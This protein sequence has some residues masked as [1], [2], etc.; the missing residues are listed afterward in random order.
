M[1]SQTLAGIA[2]LFLSSFAS[3]LGQATLPSSGTYI[4]P[5]LSQNSILDNP[6]IQKA[7]AHLYTGDLPG[8]QTELLTQAKAGNPAAQLMLGTQYVPKETFAPPSIS[9]MQAGRDQSQPK[10]IPNTN[11]SPLS[12]VFPPSYSEA[13]K[14]VDPRLSPGLRGSQ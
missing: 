6:G 11:I 1:Q 12:K 9:E 13:L 4:P 8:F 3:L 10:T 7:F 14:V 2:L 5:Q